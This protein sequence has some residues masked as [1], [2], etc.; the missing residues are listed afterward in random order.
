MI[1]YDAGKNYNLLYNTFRY[2]HGHCHI[3]ENLITKIMQKD[4]KEHEG[5]AGD[6]CILL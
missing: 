1:D 6:T 4:I 5:M 3:F 2:M